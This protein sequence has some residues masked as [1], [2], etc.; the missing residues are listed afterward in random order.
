MHIFLLVEND[1]KI[2]FSDFSD[3]SD[4]KNQRKC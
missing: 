2:N 4:K 3:F 1:V